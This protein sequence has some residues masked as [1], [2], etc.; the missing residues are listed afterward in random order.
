MARI[1]T[2]RQ[3]RLLQG[4]DLLIAGMKRTHL[5]DMGPRRANLPSAGVCA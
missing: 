3:R 2:R 5:R 4:D 1:L